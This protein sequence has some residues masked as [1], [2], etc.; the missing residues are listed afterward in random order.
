MGLCVWLSPE[1]WGDAH[2]MGPRVGGLPVPAPLLSVGFLGEPPEAPCGDLSPQTRLS[3]SLSVIRRLGEVDHQRG[4]EAA[5]VKSDVCHCPCHLTLLPDS[6]WALR[7]RDGLSVLPV[8]FIHTSFF[9][10]FVLFIQS[11]PTLLL[12]M[13]ILFLVSSLICFSV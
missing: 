10:S 5:T 9:H 2:L 1:Q 8:S 12:C 11:V 13:L 7:D 6:G 4:D 3:R